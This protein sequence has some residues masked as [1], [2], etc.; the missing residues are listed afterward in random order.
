MDNYLNEKYLKL[1]EILRGAG[2]VCIA[3]SGGVDSTLLLR[4]AA[5]TLGAKNVLAVTASSETYTGEELA[6]AQKITADAGVK[7]LTIKTSELADPAFRQ[8]TPDRCY[9]CKKN[10]FIEIIP[11]SHTYGFAVICDGS[12]IDDL[13]D[14]RPGRRALHELGIRSP[15]V[16]AGLTKDD[17]RRISREMNIPGW[18]RPANP[19]L[20]SRIPYGSEITHEKISA[21]AEAESYLKSLGFRELRVRHHGDVARIELSPGEEN[22]LHDS[23]LRHTVSDRIKSL[24]F[25]WVCLD[26]DGYRM[27]SMNEVPGIKG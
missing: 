16:D 26:L 12:N 25:T 15:M 6:G 7:H 5:D 20:A 21:V 17:V 22:L 3:F 23:G 13:N 1:T 18:D 10:F 4:A 11:I 24:G 2:R 9:Y 14:Y 27:G 19:C 8:N